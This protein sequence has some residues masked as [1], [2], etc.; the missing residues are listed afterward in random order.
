MAL[1]NSSS[2]SAESYFS[3]QPPPPSL[4][5]DID[6]VKEFVKRQAEEGRN[7]VLVTVGLDVIFPRLWPNDLL[8]VVERLFHWSSMCETPS[9]STLALMLTMRFSVRFLDNFSAGL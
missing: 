3:T 8:R 2:F 7:V 9:I 1:T 6:G 5:Q 4:E